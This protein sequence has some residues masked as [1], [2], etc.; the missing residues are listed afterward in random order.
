[1]EFKK[2]CISLLFFILSFP[3]FAQ[4]KDFEVW[5]GIKYKT[6]HSR[7][8]ATTLTL[9]SRLNENMMHFSIAFADFNLAYR[10]SKNVEVSGAYVFVR[11]NTLKNGFL[12]HHQYYG[13]LGYEK[14]INGISINYDF[15]LQNNHKDFINDAREMIPRTAGRN[16][17]KL[18]YKIKKSYLPFVYSELKHQL[19]RF[20]FP[21]LSRIR[22]GAGLGYRLNT[23]SRIEIYYLYQ[24]F[25]S[26]QPKQRY[27]LG[28]SYKIRAF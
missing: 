5:T 9:Q 12:T 13:A 23:T 6:V 28:L 24:H 10:L 26:N 4:Q 20:E 14:K 11:K 19:S 8:I 15:I 27:V 25:F 21:E 1:M 2:A 22:L 7:R 17:V 16:K 3:L 18:E